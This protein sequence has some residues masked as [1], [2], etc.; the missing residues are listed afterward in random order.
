MSAANRTL[1][2][3]RLVGR[4]GG[5]LLALA[6]LVAVDGLTSGLRVESGVFRCLAGQNLPISANVPM[7][8]DTPD[9][10][11]AE[12]DAP[13][14]SLRVDQVMPGYWMGGRL[15]AGA[16][17]TEP[18][19]A[20]GDHALVLS[21][22]PDDT[23]KINTLSYTVRV[24]PNE[25]ALQAGSPYFTE[26]L[27]G[28][29]AYPLAGSVAALGLACFGLVFLLSMRLERQLAE[30]GMAEV[31]KFKRLPEGLELEFGLGSRH[32]LAPGIEVELLGADMRA[33][34]PATVTEVRETA[35]V[36]KADLL[37]GAGPDCFVSVGGR[38][39]LNSP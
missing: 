38:A 39:L 32:G 20:A 14:I 15:F 36:A 37:E 13:G 19:L 12:A 9:K 18:G 11:M 3:R 28:V 27:L 16:V 17:Q 35:A 34:G 23:G 7:F 29:T 31:F 8:V 33:L 26:R 4:T 25:A 6:L 21:F 10:I 30:E 1:W 22:P 2:L 5:V 24:Y